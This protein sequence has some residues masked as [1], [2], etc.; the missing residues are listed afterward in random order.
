M[1]KYRLYEISAILLIVALT[2][3]AGIYGAGVH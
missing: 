3:L 2:V 1:V